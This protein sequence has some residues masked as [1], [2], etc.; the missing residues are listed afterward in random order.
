MQMD[1]PMR[2]LVYELVLEPILI[3]LQRALDLVA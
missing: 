1:H 2:T 3:M